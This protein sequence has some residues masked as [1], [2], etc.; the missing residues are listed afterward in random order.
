[1]I[2]EE[3]STLPPNTAAGDSAL[4]TLPG[5]ATIL[6]GRKAPWLDGMSGSETWNSTVYTWE[7]VT[8]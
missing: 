3:V 5:G 6:I 8:P 4:T 2:L 1:M 7:A